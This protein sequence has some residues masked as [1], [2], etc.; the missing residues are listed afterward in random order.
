L[1]LGVSYKRNVGDLR[2]SPG[3]EIMQLMKER[4]AEVDYSD[5]YIREVTQTRKLNIT[6]SSV[7]LSSSMLA[8]YD[9]VILVTDH[10]VFDYDLIQASSPLLVDTRG[11]YRGRYANV[12]HA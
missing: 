10:D 6:S 3:M 9:V 1:V 12:V 4:G 8:R 2:E 5:P 11:R 7:Q